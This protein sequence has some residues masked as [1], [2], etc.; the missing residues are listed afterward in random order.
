MERSVIV[1]GSGGQGVL[2]L[3]RLIAYTGM[4]A[5]KHVTWFPSYGAEMRGGTANCTVVISDTTVGSPIVERP[6][7]LIIMNCPS[8]KRFIKRLKDNGTIIYDASLINE[9]TCLDGD[10]SSIRKHNSIAVP[11][12]DKASA[13]GSIK[14][15]NM[16]LFGAFL[17]HSGLAEIN[18]AEE[19]LY[20]MLPQRH[21]HLIEENLRAIKIGFE[22]VMETKKTEDI[23]Y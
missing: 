5:G 15:A 14:Y 6:D 7:N 9:S 23:K 11:A 4:L 3:G 20:E 18:T 13:L 17:K 1:A 21:H 16:V 8:L 12:S 19:A 22:V 10:L 2:L